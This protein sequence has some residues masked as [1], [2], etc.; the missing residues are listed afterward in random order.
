MKP[1]KWGIIGPGRIAKMFADCVAALPDAEVTAIASR[2]AVDPEALRKTMGAQRIYSSYE[3]LAS[4]PQLDAI[5]IATPHRFHFENAMLCLQ[6]GKPV[7]VEKAF[8]VNAYEAETLIKTARENGLFIMEAMWTRFLPV[9]RQARKWLDEGTIGEVNLVR[10][11]LGFYAKR[12]LKDRLLNPD[13]AGGTLLDLAVYTL[14]V[15]QIVFPQK[16]MEIKAQGFLGET[17]V[18]EAVSVIMNFGNG[19]LSQFAC[20][21]I[22]E[23]YLEVVISGVKGCIVVHPKFYTSTRI[24]LWLGEKETQLELPFRING[25][26]YEIEEA[27]RCM[28][29]G[30]IESPIMTHQNSIDTMK[31][32]DEI[33]RQ[34]GMKYW[35]ETAPK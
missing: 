23:P 24:S 17:G 5:Y 3:E 10:S 6:H 18:D 1:F 2:S 27:Q 7:L 21:F 29:A 26:E 15:S 31:H 35:F 19:K 22:C 30:L 11:A 33:R 8:T 32:I 4:D 14:G 28:Q 13:L 12:D 34:I 16:P 25:F 20:T 9:F